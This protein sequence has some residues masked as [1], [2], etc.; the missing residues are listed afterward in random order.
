MSDGR[1]DKVTFR[2]NKIQKY[3]KT[4]EYIMN[5]DVRKLCGMSAATASR[6][7][8]SFVEEE[9]LSKYR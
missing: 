7:L 4:H 9:K 2:W 1:M 8:S 6:I 5:T 3:L